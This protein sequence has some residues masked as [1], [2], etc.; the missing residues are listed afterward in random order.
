MR[1]S[2]G[3]GLRHRAPLR[4]SSTPT[5][6]GPPHLC[7]EA[8]AAAQPSGSGSR[9]AD[10]QASMKR[11]TPPR[12]PRRP[13]RP[14]A[15]RC[16]PRGWPSARRRPTTP[17]G[18]GATSTRPSRSTGSD[19]ASPA[20]AAACKTAECSTAVCATTAPASRTPRRSPEEAQVHRVGARGR[21]GDLVGADLQRLG[22]GCPGV[23]EQQPRGPGGAVQTSWVGVPL[24]EGGEQG[25]PRGR[26]Q[27]LGRRG[28]Q[29]GPGRLSRGAHAATLT[30]APT[31]GTHPRIR[32]RIRLVCGCPVK[33]RERGRPWVCRSRREAP[34]D[35]R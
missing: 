18:G 27:R 4:T 24:V 20:Q 30:G 13:S 35:R 2:T 14:R 23:V 3:K 22:D 31:G 11:G 17:S 6:A 7:A 21:E 1:S 10:A 12:R 34:A 28:V 19:T 16:R 8:A 25:L 5:P 33:S 15:A 32:G 9:P 26:V 29:V